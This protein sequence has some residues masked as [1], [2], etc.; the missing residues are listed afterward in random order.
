MIALNYIKL[1]IW[2]MIHYF[3][4]SEVVLNIIVNNIKKSGPFLIKLVQWTLPKIENMYD[5]NP[6]N[7]EYGWFFKFEELYE[8]CDFHSLEY[9][10]K[11]FQREFK[12]DLNDKYNSI[13]E[14]ASGSIGQVYKIIDKKGNE[15][16]MKIL[17]PNVHSQVELFRILFCIIYYLKPLR[18]FINYYFPINLETFISDFQ[19][20]TNLINEANN[21]LK[22]S[23]VYE[24]NPYIIIPKIY[25]ISK[26]IIIMS[27][28]DGEVFDKLD[29]S[30]YTSYKIISLL[31]LFNKNNEAIFNFVHSDLHK[32][33]WKVRI[34]DKDKQ[35]IQL[36]IY[37]FGFCW[38][39][40]KYIYNNLKLINRIFVDM[41]VTTDIEHN[42]SKLV[43]AVD[44]FCENRFQPTL[45]RGEIDKL[46]NEGKLKL[47]D[48]IFFIRLI[49]NI[50]RKS[51]ESMDSF[52]LQCIIL[53][54]QMDR[55]YHQF[56]ESNLSNEY[57]DEYNAKYI[58]FKSLGDLINIS[59]TYKIFPEYREYIKNEL[60][61]ES[62]IRSLKRDTL[63]IYY[64][65]LDNIPLLKKLS[66]QID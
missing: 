49:L 26:D 47:T 62:E 40:P 66:L 8:N 2:S 4:P 19:M 64:K 48:P 5:I 45:I 51:N 22:F 63:F 23:K 44:I 59:E 65:K 18:S 3:Y 42:I 13:E 35:D 58:Y 28:E 9:T 53:H 24:D 10:K 38:E 39:L 29:I 27:Y 37:D 43:E 56:F 6:N 30:E 52:I 32:G 61:E 36:I 31:K 11:V 41:V 60:E 33:N 46:Y 57:G 50:T 14:I 1:G 21:N 15:Y 55:I 54:N 20:Q 34:N 16:A 12:E 17:H 7:K 25:Q